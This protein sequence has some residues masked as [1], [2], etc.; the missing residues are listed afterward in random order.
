MKFRAYLVQPLD[1]SPGAVIKRSELHERFG[2][3]RQNGISPSLKSSNVFIFTHP[4][5][6]EIHGYYDKWADD[7][8]TL[9]Y[10]G[11]GQSGD[12]T[13]TRGNKAI[14]NHKNDGRALRVF[15]QTDRPGYVR[16]KGEFQINE[17]QPFETTTEHS[18]NHGIQ[19]QVF[20]FQ[21]NKI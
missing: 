3:S 17:N 19:R 11:E 6:G 15:E 16:Y 12:Q 10:S 1:L 9:F 7:R 8:Q 4:E 13:M 14:L 2:G 21:L 5:Q 18:T 20:I